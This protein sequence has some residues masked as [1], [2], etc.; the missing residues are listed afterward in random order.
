M[1][2]RHWLVG[3]VSAATAV[4]LA[5]PAA[6]AAPAAPSLG[7]RSL[8]SVLAADGDTFDRNWYDYDILAQAVGAVLAAKPTSKVAVLA[9]GTVPLTAFLPNDRAF[10]VLAFDLTKRWPGSE[11]QTFTTLA[12]TV[13]ID[14]IESVL[15]YHVVPGATIDKQAAANADG[16]Q[17][18]TALGPTIGVR[19]LS[20]QLPLIVLRDK[21]PND[22]NPIVNPFALDINKGNRQIAHGIVFVLRPADL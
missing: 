8:A 6:S 5:A 2:L 7:T 10:Q 20:R 15:L 1:S 13:G 16:A 18:T 12:Q 9:D 19:V 22:V 14:A 21:D 11:Q 3:A 17:L 4:G